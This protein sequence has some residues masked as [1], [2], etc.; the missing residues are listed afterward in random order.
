MAFSQRARC[1]IW[2]KSWKLEA[3]IWAGSGVM[4]YNMHN[5]LNQNHVCEMTQGS[6]AFYILAEKT[7]FVAGNW[8][9]TPCLFNGQI[10]FF[11]G[12]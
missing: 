11:S 1:V 8:D 2:I 9:S 7:F 6:R 10:W 12:F 4:V 3:L 5:V